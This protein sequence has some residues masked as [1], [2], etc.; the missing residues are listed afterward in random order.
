MIVVAAN[1]SFVIKKAADH[2]AP[3]YGISYKDITGNIFTG[4]KIDDLKFKNLQIS[5]QIKF[6]WNP[7]K[8]LYK[9]IAISEVRGEN[10]DVDAIKALIASFPGSEENESTAPFPLVITVGKV[11]V[12]VN[13]FTEQNITFEKTLLEAEDILYANDEVEVGDLHLQLDTSVADLK[14]Q[15]SLEDGEVIIKDF[16]LKE[17]DSQT[18]ETM[19]IPKVEENTTAKIQQSE[20]T[21]ATKKEEPINPLIPKTAVVKHFSASLKPRSYKG[22]AIDRLTINIK[23]LKADILKIME[24][25]KNALSVQDLAVDFSS[26]IGHIALDAGMQKSVVNIQKLTVTKLDTMALQAMFVPES[27]KTNT[28]EQNATVAKVD[29]TNI[30]A[31]HKAPR[32]NL[33]PQKVVLESFHTDILPATFDPVHILTFV[34][35]GREIQFDVDKL[36]VEK[37]ELDFI[38]KTNLSNISQHAKIKNNHLNGHIILTPNKPLFDLYAPTIRKE[39]IGDI[40][41][42]FTAA[43]EKITVDL[44]A[45]A[46]HLLLIKEEVNA[47][48]GNMTDLNG[49]ETNATVPFNIDINHLNTHVVYLPESGKLNANADINVSSPYVKDITFH[50]DF[51]MADDAMDYDGVLKAGEVMLPNGKVLTFLNDFSITFTGNQHQVKTAID[52]KGLK[53]YFNVPDFTTKGVFHLE[54]TKALKVRELAVL[55]AELN[56]TQLNAV[57]DVPLNFEKLVPITAKA[58]ITSNVANLTADFVYGDTVILDLLATVPD[59]SLLKNLD[60]HIRWSALSPL[61]VNTRMGEKDI[62]VSLKTSKIAANMKMLPFAGTVDGKI[63]VSGVSATLKGDKSGTIKLQSDVS[64]FKTLLGTVDQFYHVEDL[65]KV[66]GKLNLSVLIAPKGD[67]T[68]NLR[69]PQVIYHADRKTTHN[70]DD[71]VLSLG[72]KGSTLLLK[73]YQLTYNKMHFFAQKPSVIAFKD[74][75]VTI[76]QIWL[77]DALKVAGKVDLKKMQ[78]EITASAEKF[79]FSHEMIDLDSKIDIKALLD[80]GST[81]VKGTIVLLNGD[82]HYDLSTKSF[83][84]DSDILIVQEMKKKEPSPFMDHLTLD[85]KVITQKPLIYKEGPVDVKAKVDLS[86]NKAIYSDP[87]VLGSIDLVDGSSYTFQGKKFLLERSHIYLTGDP[88]KPMLDITVKYQALRHLITI[89]VTG[90]PAVPNILF[91]SVPS[92]TK[93]QILSMILFDSEEGAATNDAND[94][95]KMMGGAMAKSAL[96]DLGVKIDHLVFGEGNSVE[97]G[98]KL[99]DDITVIYI[100]GEIPKMEM[101]YTYS[102]SVEIVVGASEE[103]ESMDIVY[104]KDFN[105]GGDEDIVIKRKK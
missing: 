89:N 15:A 93:E 50:A 51:E 71:V 97:V 105:M 100:N 87:M 79:H 70:I 90:T 95:M 85:V 16:S 30:T 88:A 98:K 73:S 53:G 44:S 80:N 41:L 32:N 82:I 74:Q 103:S 63:R 83:P 19:F 72:M 17:I 46:K 28:T 49:S 91:S 43:K 38:G 66:E 67:V 21:T 12:S 29:D 27:N 8:I 31:V 64:S 9:R 60:K 94:M 78:G 42:D 2:F 5:K 3:E 86:I 11:Y 48:D 77:N 25:R 39:A 54:T 40:A 45:E 68:L 56:A 13:P 1:S 26:D 84:S 33:I 61:K 62:A 55:P 76:R 7:S 59:D 69:S 58:K 65:P 22:A 99:T 23:D 96:N 104:I 35:D 4:V 102:P 52:S 6:S 36:L 24:N 34:F 75:V 57:I 81:N 47:A 37:G 14:L 18:L 10:I 20:E 101:K 92:L